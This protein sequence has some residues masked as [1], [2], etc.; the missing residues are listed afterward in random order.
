ML[1]PVIGLD[2]HPSNEKRSCLCCCRITARKDGI[3]LQSIPRC[4]H[5]RRLNR[6]VFIS[7]QADCSC[8]VEYLR[9]ANNL[10]KS[11]QQLEDGAIEYQ[12]EML[13]RS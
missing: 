3:Q 7:I 1:A 2:S 4:V 13:Q 12:V 6:I 9:I 8:T 11:A 10:Q 5:V